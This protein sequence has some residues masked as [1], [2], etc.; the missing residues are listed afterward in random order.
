MSLVNITR[1]P[2]TS[3]GSRMSRS[4]E[5]SLGPLQQLARLTGRLQ[6]ECDGR[7]EE[8]LALC[9]PRRSVASPQSSVQYPR[10]AWSRGM[11]GSD[12]EVGSLDTE[13][14]FRFKRL[15]TAEARALHEV[16]ISMTAADGQFVLP[17]QFA[18]DTWFRSTR[19]RE[20]PTPIPCGTWWPR[21][22]RPK[23]SNGPAVTKDLGNT[24]PVPS[25]SGDI[26]LTMGDDES[27]HS[28]FSVPYSKGQPR[29]MFMVV[30]QTAFLALAIF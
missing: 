30:E 21:L 20:S 24:L 7:D 2:E 3:T 10:M 9:V 22:R 15:N 14:E 16:V 27:A 5:A 26:I 8:T 17:R 11:N 25:V 12:R 29:W 19:S 6:E 28:I 23:G 4:R 18:D 13:A 1:L